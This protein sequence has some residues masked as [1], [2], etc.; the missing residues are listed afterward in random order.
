MNGKDKKLVLFEGR[1][2]RRTWYNNEWFFVLED[3]VA[4]LTDSKD[5]RQYIKKMKQRDIS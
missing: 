2:I 5:P 3:I 1:K 4:V